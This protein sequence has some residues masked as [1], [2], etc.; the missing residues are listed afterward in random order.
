[1]TVI[2]PVRPPLEDELVAQ[3]AAIRE[4]VGHLDRCR[5]GIHEGSRC[6]QCPYQMATMPITVIGWGVYG[7]PITVAELRQVAG[8][9]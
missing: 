6:Q 7:R 9:A 5:H 1:M 4:L 3:L 2:A 8:V